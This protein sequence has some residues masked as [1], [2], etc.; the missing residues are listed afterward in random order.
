MVLILML[1]PLDLIM[2]LPGML[3]RRI[4]LAAPK[5]LDRGEKGTLVVTVLKTKP[6]PAKRIKA[7]VKIGGALYAARKTAAAMRYL[8]TLHAPA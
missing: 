2:S 6:F 1:V 4:I 8:S 5:V 7:W 3:T